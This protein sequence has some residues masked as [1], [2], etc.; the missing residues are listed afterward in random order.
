T[1]YP[2]KTDPTNNS[3]AIINHLIPHW[4]I[5]ACAVSFKIATSPAGANI[6]AD[7]K[8][9][10]SFVCSMY[11][12]H[13]SFFPSID[14]S[15]CSIAISPPVVNRMAEYCKIFDKR[16]ESL[17]GYFESLQKGLPAASAQTSCASIY[18]YF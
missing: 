9:T 15:A 3:S 16:L 8:V 7:D 6:K 11:V 13:A 18:V 10:R 12:L 4:P 2:I 1:T 14:A 17:S 5:P